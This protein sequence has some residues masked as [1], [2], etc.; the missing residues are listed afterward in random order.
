[1]RRLRRLVQKRS[2]RWSEGVCVLEG[3]DLVEAALNGGA[4]FEAIY[5]DSAEAASTSLSALVDLAGKAGVRLY[6]LEPGVLEII[7]DAKTPQPVLAAIRFPVTPLA[8]LGTDGLVL[9]L[10]G[11]RDPG[12]VGTIIRSA[13]AAGVAAVVLTGQSVD[14]FNPKTLRAT[15]GSIFHVP[16]AV[17]ELDEALEHFRTGGA[18]ILATVIRGGT[19]LRDVDFTSPAAV[20]IGNE[21]EGLDQQTIGRC[22]DALSIPMDGRCESLNAGVAA[23]LV[24]FEALWQRQDAAGPRSPSSL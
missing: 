2:L 11:L 14:P 18:R 7:A 24:A 10:H 20:V 19:P 22:D 23:S 17:C 1:M 9:V 8:Q 16:L 12:N 21:A 4:E 6:G 3:P 5:L 13:D 15:A